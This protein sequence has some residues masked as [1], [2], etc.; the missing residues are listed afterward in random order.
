MVSADTRAQKARASCVKVTHL[1]RQRSALNPLTSR[2]PSPKIQETG[3]VRRDQETQA[4]YPPLGRGAPNSCLS[5][6]VP[7]LGKTTTSDGNCVKGK[8]PAAYFSMAAS[9]RPSPERLIPSPSGRSSFLPPSLHSVTHVHCYTYTHCHMLSHAVTPS[10]HTRC[11][12]H[13][14]TLSHSHIHSHTV[15]VSGSHSFSHT[16]GHI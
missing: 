5:P 3:K 8:N 4:D 11:H 13:T 10:H 2:R 7:V 16:R 14:I 15:A 1:M 12:F 6:S 9:D